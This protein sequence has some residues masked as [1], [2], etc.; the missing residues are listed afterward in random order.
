MAKEEAIKELLKTYGET[1]HCISQE[2]YQALCF[3]ALE[4]IE[5]LAAEN[6]RL[7]E[8]QDQWDCEEY[9]YQLRVRAKTKEELLE[10]AQRLI[11]TIEAGKG[12]II[13]AF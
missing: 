9:P 4:R 11:E 13:T 12:D 5:Q 10:K 8:L 3:T 2:L 6:R 1:E 7:Q